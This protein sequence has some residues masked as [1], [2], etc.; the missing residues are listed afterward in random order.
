MQKCPVYLYTNLFTVI[1]DLDQNTRTYNNM[2]Q[3]DL[4]I[5]KGLQNKIQFQFKNSDQKLL[6]IS[7]ETFVFTMFDAINRRQLLEKSIEIIDDGVTTSTKGLGVLTL[8]ESDTLDLDKGI[9]K[10]SVKKINEIGTYDLTYA[11]TYYGI[12]GV[13]EILEDVYPVLQP[14]TEAVSFRPQYNHDLDAQRYEYYSDSMQAHPEYNGNSALH[15]MAFYMSR[16][17]GQIII[18]GT[19]ENSPSIFSNYAII[20]SKTYTGYSGIDYLNFNGV[21]SKVRIRHIPVKNPFTQE[22]NDTSYSGT[23]DK[24]L[25][26][27]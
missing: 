23:V 27:S 18:E 24:V 5:Q 13:L 20:N 17:K 3:R 22:N 26:R 2:Y 4:K 16:Y 10:F 12:N 19:M 21:W 8:S 11:N 15:T 6:P 1:L 7:N 9:Y 25:Y 14:S